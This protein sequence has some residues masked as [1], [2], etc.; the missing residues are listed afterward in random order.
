M[1]SLNVDDVS[2]FENF[3]LSLA[4]NDFCCASMFLILSL[5]L[6]CPR[7]LFLRVGLGCSCCMLRRMLKV[8]PSNVYFFAH[9][10]FNDIFQLI[11]ISYLLV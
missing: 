5:F 2:V 6:S 7:F 1:C 8:L 11:I 9:N 4:F 10:S 3:W